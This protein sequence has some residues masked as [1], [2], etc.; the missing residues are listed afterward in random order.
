MFKEIF[1]FELNYRKTRPATYIY[2]AIIF[3]MCFLAVTT[4]VVRIGGAVGQVKQN[5][6]IVITQ[7]SLIVSVFL[8][9]IASAVMG[10]AV[11][12]D[13]EHN[14]EAILFSTPMKKIDYLMG[15]F[16]GSFAILLFIGAAI[17]VAFIIGDVMWW[18]DKQKLMPIHIWNY[19]QPFF[20]FVVPNLFFSGALLFMSGTLSRKSIVIYT[21]GILLLVLYLASQSLLRD[22]EQKNI[23]SLIDPFG[24]RSF[25]YATQYWTPAERNN[26]LV[27]LEG[28]VL[29]NR[30]L[31]VGLGVVALVITY[32]GFSFNVV[33]NSIVRRKTTLDEIRNLIKPEN[34]K[35]P[36]ATQ[37][38]NRY[39]HVRQFF[40]LSWFYCTSVVKEI[41]FL[42][43]VISGILLLFLN[44]INLGELY[45]TKS[46]PTTYG[47]VGLISGSFGLFFLIIVVLYT[48]ELVWKERSVKINLILD[49]LPIPDFITLIAK[50][51]GLMLI[52]IGMIFVLIICGVFIQIAYGYFNFELPI[53]F[54]SLYSETMAFLV[55]YTLLSF[56][57]QVMVN[58]KF[59]GYAICVVFFI[60]VSI[61]GQ[62]G[63]EHPLFQFGSGSLGTYS[64]MNVFG[65]YVSPFSW[66]QIYWLGFTVLLFGI[67]VVFSARGS[68][69]V[70]KIRWK[71]GKLRLTRQLMTFISAFALVFISS[72]F[73]IFYNTNVINEYRNKKQGQKRQADYEK[74]LKKFEFI[75]Q[76]KIVESK[77]KVDIFPKDRDFVAEGFY[78]LKNKSTE[79]IK[80][81]HVQQG[82]DNEITLDYLKFDRETKIKEHF[83]DFRYMIYELTEPL[84]P[85]DSVKMNF[86]ES[87]VTRGF[88]EQGSNTNVI[89]NGT[90]FNNGYFPSLGYNEN[91]ELNDDD[92]RKDNG[93]KK[94]ERMLERND[95]RG[96]AQSLFGDDADHIRF[97]IEVSTDPNQIAIAPGY[98]QKEW[99]ADGRN[100][101]SYKMDAPMCNFY[102][103]VSARYVVK[104]DK[105]ND[106]NLEIYYHPGHEY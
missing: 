38:V 39:S 8:C 85:G 4:D 60:F 6:P 42:G 83:D 57:V 36:A 52:Y 2:F 89:Y 17:W 16:W 92:D 67:A 10:V 105:W 80:D 15:R 102:S 61:M 56:F 81:I 49:T 100:Y 69:A 97:D 88:V 3:L 91:F 59:I 28:Y 14:T 32:F 72:G 93:L 62:I 5:S 43:I 30:L 47:V 7:M 27:R 25:S 90:F 13:F 12:R 63:L 77:L 104:R 33:R 22:L 11:L 50:F 75:I 58:N 82:A 31:W 95:P 71:V 68:E 34:V 65:H 29:Y 35:I 74:Q 84:K 66:L 79:I 21:Q 94:K 19:L 51:A 9:L 20:L 41:P 40:K 73:Y 64:D 96:L 44:A 101:F 1:K 86:K 87:F 18:R 24:L 70:M 103:I 45:G 55:L 26:S 48:G 76:P 46:Y 98:L 99:K 37:L 53:Y 23:A 78:Y 106:V 54:E